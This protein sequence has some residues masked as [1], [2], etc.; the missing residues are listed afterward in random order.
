MADLTT[1]VGSVTLRN[2]VL[3]AA[4][5]NVRTGALLRAAADG[6]A[7]GLVGKTVSVRPADDT[8]PTIRRTAAAGLT[9]SETWSEIPVERYIAHLLAAKETG[10]PVIAS[11]GY[12]PTEVARLGRLL[13]RET[14]P[15]A[16]E[17]STHYSG[18]EISPLIDTAKALRDAVTVPIWMKLSPTVSD[19]AGVVRG[20]EAEVDA[21]VAINSFGPVLDFDPEHP[22][23]RLGTEN[24]TGWLSGAPILPIA[25]RIVHEVSQ[26][27][28]KPVIGT[29][30][31][32][33][34]IDA[35]KFLMAGA[36]AVQVCSAAIRRGNAVYGHI[37]T[38]IEG[39][40][41]HHGYRSVREIIG[42]YRAEHTHYREQP[43]MHVVIESCTGC[44]AC[45]NQCVHGAISFAAG[46]ARIDADLC[47]GCGY[48]QDIC[49]YNAMLLKEVEP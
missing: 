36:Q 15:D 12:S 30:G 23:A 16:I 13:E 1:A 35:I 42:L 7:G 22:V 49:R 4:G 8:R 19:L 17:F 32:A 37:A 33:K 5:P 38:E 40:L 27:Q 26:L 34:G 20:A 24:G 6:G 14:A 10:L 28:S 31:I 29:G 43:R 25:L 2:P 44:K 3:P 46:K 48:C 11:I 9:N 21:F 41:A 45:L 47:I 39:W 18:R